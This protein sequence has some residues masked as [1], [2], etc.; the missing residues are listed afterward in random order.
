MTG[1]LARPGEEASYR[2]G[3]SQTSRG[4]AVPD[5]GQ[6]LV[7]HGRDAR[8][9]GLNCELCAHQQNLASEPSQATTSAVAAAPKEQ[10]G[11]SQGWALLLR[12]PG[13]RPTWPRGP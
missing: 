10:E 4:V 1:S 6:I 9:T 5:P 11:R 12:T 2:E 7:C 8:A 3:H 13:T